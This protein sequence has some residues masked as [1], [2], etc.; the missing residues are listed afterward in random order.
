MA[1]QT[2]W[3]SG[4]LLNEWG[5]IHNAFCWSERALATN[6]TERSKTSWG[7]P[8]TA[9]G[10]PAFAIEAGGKA[11]RPLVDSV[12]TCAL[13]PSLTLALLRLYVCVCVCLSLQP[14]RPGEPWDFVQ[15]ARHVDI[16]TMGLCESCQRVG[17]QFQFPGWPGGGE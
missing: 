12:G 14:P 13:P 15:C 9:D 5:T 6:S 8:S 1:V 11:V 10:G 4:R 16:A 2:V 17:D 7:E 3:Q